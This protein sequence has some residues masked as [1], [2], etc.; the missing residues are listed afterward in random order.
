MWK[1]YKA[2]EKFSSTRGTWDRESSNIEPQK[3]KDIIII[4]RKLQ[5][6][7]IQCV[8]RQMRFFFSFHGFNW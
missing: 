6:I 2:R 4:D 1:V 3:V 7:Y 5:N 8:F